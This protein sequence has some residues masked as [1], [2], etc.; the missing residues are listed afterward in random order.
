MRYKC[1][2]FLFFFCCFAIVLSK[3]FTIV[4]DWYLLTLLFLLALPMLSV[5]SLNGL[6]M[7]WYRQEAFWRLKITELD[8]DALSSDKNLQKKK[9]NEK[10][11]EKNRHLTVHKWKHC[12]FLFF[13]FPIWFIYIFF[14]NLCYL[15][16]LIMVYWYIYLLVLIPCCFFFCFFFFFWLFFSL[17]QLFKSNFS[18]QT[19]FLFF[20]L[21]CFLFSC[22]HF[23]L[24]ILLLYIYLS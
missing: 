12:F 1:D 6:V 3:A 19:R 11:K 5:L 18:I 17:C 20:S 2:D 21:Q 9:R 8:E 10:I 23:F 24:L 13:F 14:Y 22:L 15:L 4:V 16:M 7:V